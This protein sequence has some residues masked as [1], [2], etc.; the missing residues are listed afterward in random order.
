MTDEL[1]IAVKL[2]KPNKSITKRS[3]LSEI[4]KLY[5]PNGFIAPIVVKAKMLMQSIWRL[6]EL[7]WDD[8]VPPNI[9]NEWMEMYADLPLLSNFKTKR[10]LNTS[11]RS[12][13][14]IH[15][16][17][18]A[19]K[20]AYGTA[21]YVRIEDENKQVSCS[22]LSAKSRVAPLK[23]ITIPRL[24]LLAAVMASEQLEA[25]V[26]ACEFED[27]E[28]TLW[29]DSMIVLGWI[30]KHPSDLKAFVSN[31]VQKIQE[32]TKCT[33]GNTYARETIQLT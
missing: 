4:A 30:K 3:I 21:I 17:C 24:E 31:R 11:K 15:A 22:L 25:I 18:D 14:Q 16:F 19:S 8:D 26:Q 12:R 2:D 13:V 29:S 5:D 9:S 7:D 23:E 27:A 1:T 28:I 10:W 32:I 20:A 33:N 6:K